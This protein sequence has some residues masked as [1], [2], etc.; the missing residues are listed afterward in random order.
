MTSVY[1]QTWRCARCD[2]SWAKSQGVIPCWYCGSDEHVWPSVDE[3]VIGGILE[4][5]LPARP[6]TNLGA[7]ANIVVVDEVHEWASKVLDE[8]YNTIMRPLR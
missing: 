8:I 3:C 7:S 6:A 4:L 1:H 5:P 2:V